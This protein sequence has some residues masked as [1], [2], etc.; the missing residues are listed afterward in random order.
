MITTNEYAYIYTANT[1]S[2][3]SLIRMFVFDVLWNYYPYISMTW[4]KSFGDERWIQQIVIMPCECVMLGVCR[5]WWHNRSL[6][7]PLQSATDVAH[8]DPLSCIWTSWCA[9]LHIDDDDEQAWV[10][11]WKGKYDCNMHR[12]IYVLF[13]VT[14]CLTVHDDTMYWLITCLLCT[15][16]KHVSAF[17]LWT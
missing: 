14:Y 5:G 11:R 12:E 15:N 7:I 16:N 9:S 10:L 6:Y 3:S 17:D 8:F 2:F 4:W 1:F 13:Y